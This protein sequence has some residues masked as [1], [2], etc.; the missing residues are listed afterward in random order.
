MEKP[1]CLRLEEAENE[2]AAV[3]NRHKKEG[4][5]PCFLLEPILWKMYMQ[6]AEGKRTE[7]MLVRKNYKEESEVA[8]NGLGAREEIDRS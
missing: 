2:I 8:C 1:L 3:I 7:Q 5:L 6:V 4:A